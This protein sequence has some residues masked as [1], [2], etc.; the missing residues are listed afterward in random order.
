M[1]FRCTLRRDWPGPCSKLHVIQYPFVE[2]AGWLYPLSWPKSGVTEESVQTIV[3]S[4]DGCVS[5]HF[6]WHLVWEISRRITMN[7]PSFRTNW[8]LLK[9]LPDLLYD[10][11]LSF[12]ASPIFSWASKTARNRRCHFRTFQVG[13]VGVLRL[14]PRQLAIYSHLFLRR[15]DWNLWCFVEKITEWKA[16]TWQLPSENVW[17]GTVGLKWRKFFVCFTVL[18]GLSWHKLSLFLIFQRIIT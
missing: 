15:W 10:I 9:K 6:G 7:Y 16:E 18:P 4:F 13:H 1:F 17:E 3:T 12:V 11:Y 8:R 2:F 14:F 5:H